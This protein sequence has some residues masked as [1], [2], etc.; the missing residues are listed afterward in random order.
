MRRSAGKR[1]A[2]RAKRTE[3]RGIPAR[4]DETAQRARQGSPVAKRRARI[5]RMKRRTRIGDP[6]RSFQH[7]YRRQHQCRQQRRRRSSGG[8]VAECGAEGDALRQ[9]EPLPCAE[10]TRSGITNEGESGSGTGTG[11]KPPRRV[12]GRSCRGGCRSLVRAE[13]RGGTRPAR[14]ATVRARCDARGCRAGWP[15]RGGSRR[16]RNRETR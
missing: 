3:A 5:H 8:A 14:G 9:V 7:R 16:C 1:S 6:Q 4:R 2:Q 10:R 15:C 13:S 11:R 12:G